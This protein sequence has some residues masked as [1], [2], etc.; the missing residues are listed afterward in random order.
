LPSR[1]PDAVGQVAAAGDATGAP[2]R[3]PEAETLPRFRAVARQ[4]EFVPPY[5]GED[6]RRKERRASTLPTTLDTRKSGPDRRL[7]SRISLK[8]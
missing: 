6:R 8:V 2:R 4:Y 1:N 7:A 3:N 5:T